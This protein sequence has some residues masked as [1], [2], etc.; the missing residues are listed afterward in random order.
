MNSSG[1]QPSVQVEAV[2]RRVRVLRLVALTVLLLN[3]G[4]VAVFI[5]TLPRSSSILVGT[6][7]GFQIAY[8]A[9][10]FALAAGA[11]LAFAAPV[12][13]WRLVPVML[14]RVGLASATAIA[15]FALPFF[16]VHVTPLLVDGCPTGYIAVEPWGG[17]SASVGV[18]DSV[19]FVPSGR[20][21]LDGGTF[22]EGDYHVRSNG[23]SLEV[24]QGD[25]VDGLDLQLPVLPT[26]ACD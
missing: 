8:C 24:W 15:L 14:A 6:V 12:R 17:L 1:T 7:T 5:V 11:A 25:R 9:G 21:W 13:Q 26:T 2:A 10:I 4:I 3:L 19:W 22:A 16:S 20:V 23:E 18:R